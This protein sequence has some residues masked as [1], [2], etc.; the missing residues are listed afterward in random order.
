[1]SRWLGRLG[2]VVAVF[3]TTAGACQ[4]E[5]EGELPTP[6]ELDAAPFPTG[7]ATGGIEAT[8][9]RLTSE[10][11]DGTQCFH[12]I[13]LSGKGEAQLS[14]GCSTGGVEQIAADQRTWSARSTVGDYASGAGSVWLRVVS[15]DGLEE[16]L[17]LDVYEFAA[18]GTELRS[19][20]R[21]DSTTRVR[22]Y[23][24]VTGAAPRDTPACDP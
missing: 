14:Q 7:A 10:E 23:T 16:S 12:L 24:L 4:Q 6:T 13:R 15:W 1:V 3:A 11:P 2:V 8:Y 5:Y 22:P 17:N 18:C 9:A 20:P 21:L 19:P